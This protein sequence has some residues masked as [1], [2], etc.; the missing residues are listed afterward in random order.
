MVINNTNDLYEFC[1][2]YEIKLIG[3][4]LNVKNTTPIYLNCSRC[5]VEVK[6]SYK[7]LIKYKDS[8]NV[9]CYEK[10]CCRCFRMMM[11]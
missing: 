1:I 10:Y 9:A 3:E 8:E 11:Y 4:Y 7:R 6:K 5:D 2:K